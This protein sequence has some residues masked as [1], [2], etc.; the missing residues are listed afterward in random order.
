MGL[1]SRRSE[2]GM[3]LQFLVR[4]EPLFLGKISS[5]CTYYAANL[6]GIADGS[7]RMSPRKY[8]PVVVTFNPQRDPHT[9]QPV[10][11]IRG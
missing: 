10:D 11:L 4:F 5:H 7:S 8:F 2:Q 1:S 6:P 9:Y 3:I